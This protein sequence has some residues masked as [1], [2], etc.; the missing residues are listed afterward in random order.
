MHHTG[1]GDAANVVL[2]QTGLENRFFRRKCFL[3]LRFLKELQG[4]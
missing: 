2:K 4:L 3:V 1:E